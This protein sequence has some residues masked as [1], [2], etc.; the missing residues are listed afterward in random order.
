M[1]WVRKYDIEPEDASAR[2]LL[3]HPGISKKMIEYDRELAGIFD[4]VWK[5]D[6]A[7]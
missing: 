2:K 6:Y 4:P 1:E 5:K 7:G 3:A